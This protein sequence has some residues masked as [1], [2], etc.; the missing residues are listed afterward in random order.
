MLPSL[1]H[2]SQSAF[3]SRH[4]ITDNVVVAFKI[5]DSMKKHIHKK[6]GVMAIKLDMIKTYDRVEFS[7]L[8]MVITQ[9]AFPSHFVCLIMSYLNI[10]SF[11]ILY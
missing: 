9:M 5:F 8:E 1:I 7:Y 6:I 11:F 4:L 10:V 2:E 3:L